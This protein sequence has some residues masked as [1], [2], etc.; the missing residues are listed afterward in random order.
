M[1]KFIFTISLGEYIYNDLFL[2]IEFLLLFV[3]PWELKNYLIWKIG[4]Y[5]LPI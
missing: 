4:D 5:K 1:Q 2:T 3:C